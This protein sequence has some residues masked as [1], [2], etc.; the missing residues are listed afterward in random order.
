[1]LECKAKAA[2]K[3]SLFK[4]CTECVY[5]QEKYMEESL[6]VKILAQ[7]FGQLSGL[8]EALAEISGLCSTQEAV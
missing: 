2:E 6:D 5:E 3:G 8:G 4:C 1:M 7:T